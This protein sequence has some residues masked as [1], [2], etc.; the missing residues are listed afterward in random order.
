[1]ANGPVLKIKLRDASGH[2][3]AQPCT[4]RLRHQTSGVLTIV[5]RP[6]RKD[7]TVTDLVPGVYQ[8]QVHPTSYR[9]V[10]R[11]VMVKPAG[12][13]EETLNFPV[14]PAKVVDAE[15]PPFSTLSGDGQ[16]ILTNTAALFG[17]EHISG[18]ALYAALDDDHIKKAGLLNI[19]AKASAVAFSNQRTV[20]SYILSL[21]ELRGDRFF[22]I[23]D[24]ALREQ[25]K[26]SVLDDLFYAAPEELHH[27]TAGFDPAGSYK[28][29]D[30]YGN[31][32]LT[33]STNGVEWRA[34]IDIDDAGGLAH[35]FQVLRNQITD[36]PTHPY[37]IHEILV[38]FQHL[39]PG[40][41]LD[42]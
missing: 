24:Q 3:L 10:G 12:V 27:P 31:L 28:T 4:I 39:D 9:P 21:V 16:R 15:F 6:A 41:S 5:N 20:A 30:H 7:V 8:T 1:M 11:F 26:N 36:K 35:V 29:F 23:V 33:F 40:Y 42:V 18:A 22:A 25:T 13:T 17:Y 14:D 32:Q 37:D 38:A 2:P 19:F 34:D